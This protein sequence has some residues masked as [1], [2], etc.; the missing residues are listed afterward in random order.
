MLLW[1]MNKFTT[2]NRKIAKNNPS[3]GRGFSPSLYQP[4][5]DDNDWF[6]HSKSKEIQ[7]K[8]SIETWTSLCTKIEKFRKITQVNDGGWLH[9]RTRTRTSLMIT[10]MT[11]FLIHSFMIIHSKIDHLHSPVILILRIICA[12]S[13]ID[14]HAD[15]RNCMNWQA[16][17]LLLIHIVYICI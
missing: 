14:D 16:A 9:V 11:D 7:R 3:Q 5:P 12:R 8:C 6:S 17:T 10:L 2:K 13:M 4:P 15:A 1:N